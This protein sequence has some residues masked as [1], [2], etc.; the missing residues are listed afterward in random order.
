[1]S[2]LKLT[3][4][5]KI[6]DIYNDEGKGVYSALLVDLGNL[7]KSLSP[8]PFDRI[9]GIKLGVKCADWLKNSSTLNESE[10]AVVIGLTERKYSFSNITELFK[11]TD[12]V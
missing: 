11:N 6:V 12:F 2:E 1:M 8:S 10:N 9:F 7:Q 3:N 4:N 5:R